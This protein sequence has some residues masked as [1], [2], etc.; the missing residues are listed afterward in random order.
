MS[1]QE[2]MLTTHSWSH[3]TI[4]IVITFIAPEQVIEVDISWDDINSENWSNFYDM[5]RVHT[6]CPS[7]VVS[8]QWEAEDLADSYVCIKLNKS[9]SILI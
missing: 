5:E 4:L 9:V 2:N 1:D 7:H 8:M 3:I 6:K